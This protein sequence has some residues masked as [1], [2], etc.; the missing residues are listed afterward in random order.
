MCQRLHHTD[1]LPVINTQHTGSCA[2]FSMQSCYSHEPWPLVQNN[3]ILGCP[4]CIQ[5]ALYVLHNCARLDTMSRQR[6]IYSLH[7]RH[8]L[9]TQIPVWHQSRRCTALPCAQA[10]SFAMVANDKE[11][12]HPE[13]EDHDLRARHADAGSLPLRPTDED[14]ALQDS[15][16]L[17]PRWCLEHGG[18]TH[19]YHHITAIVLMAASDAPMYWLDFTW[20]N[21]TLGSCT[22]HFSNTSR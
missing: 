14:M 8:N 20:V 6:G 9:A 22:W 15:T 21:T 5:Q 11:S 18:G 3:M 7:Q 13:L 2:V 1:F 16:T 17:P 4:N 19:W 10:T 12:T